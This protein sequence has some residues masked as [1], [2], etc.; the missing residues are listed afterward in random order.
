M[1]D[2][3]RPLWDFDDLETT[4]KR[5]REQLAAEPTDA[6]RAEVLTQL[7]RVEGLR[8]EAVTLAGDD[9]V[10]RARIDL[11]RGRLRR[12]GGDPDA[13]RPLFVSAFDLASEAGQTF[14]A[15]DAAHMAALVADGR[16]GFVEWTRRGIDLAESDEG[17]RHWL[18]P[19]YNNLGWE[20][21]E[22][23][24][25]AQALDAFE[26]QLVAR[27]AEDDPQQTI[28]ISRYAI[29]KALRALGR[30]GEAIPMLETAV[31]WAD[32]ESAPDGWFHEELAEEYAAVGRDAEAAEQAKAAIPLLERDD[33]DFPN[34]AD[35][36]TRLRTIAEAQ[37]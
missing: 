36:V 9:K 27:E 10:A 23:G 3:L 24:D 2:R 12:S 6:G 28:E 29:G 37:V 22:A 35:R 5:L 4:E 31:A 25:Y 33:P 26:R 19:L 30:S 1:N 8:D 11:E 13:A 7:A 18:G 21:Y 16:D 34:D 15:T 14:I 32:G 20:F 17:A